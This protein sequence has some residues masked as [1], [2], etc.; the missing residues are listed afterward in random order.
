VFYAAFL[1][2]QIGFVIFWQKKIS[3]KAV[4]KMLKKLAT[5]YECRIVILNFTPD[6]IT[7]FAIWLKKHL[8]I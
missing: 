8:D 2:L 5:E 1:I 7:K 4:H 3:A 6:K